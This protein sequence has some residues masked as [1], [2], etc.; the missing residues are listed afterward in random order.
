MLLPAPALCGY[1]QRPACGGSPL[2]HIH[3]CW[4]PGPS[5]G[6]RGLGRCGLYLPSSGP[7]LQQRSEA[8]SLGIRRRWRPGHPPPGR[9][10][11][12][13]VLA[14]L[15]SLQT[16]RHL[17]VL[18]GRASTRHQ[19][20][21][22]SPLKDTP[23][24]QTH[25]Q[26][27]TQSDVVRASQARAEEHLH[28]EKALPWQMQYRISGPAG[29]PTWHRQLPSWLA[30]TVFLQYCCQRLPTAV[31]WKVEAPAASHLQPRLR[32]AVPRPRSDDRRF[33]AAAAAIP[34]AGC[35][36]RRPVERSRLPSGRRSPSRQHGLGR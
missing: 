19:F 11:K 26:G 35:R 15:R 27:G 12:A 13:A 29:R 33:L 4:L 28:L 8:G 31:D 9:R 22:L 10:C 21:R 32:R 23:A 7:R 24:A 20:A 6:R 17:R 36:G 5:W 16:R 3:H 18:R 30:Q 25:N 34:G 2:L 1:Q 14:R